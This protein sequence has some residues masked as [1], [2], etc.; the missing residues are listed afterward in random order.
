M[1]FLIGDE[2]IR[3]WK[4]GDKEGD[5]KP[6]VVVGTYEG[7]L[8]CIRVHGNGVVKIIDQNPEQCRKTGKTYPELAKIIE[9]LK[10]SN[11]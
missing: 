5:D 6:T 8:Q 10:K 11:E 9:Q 4:F 3:H 2:V 1:D 7:Y